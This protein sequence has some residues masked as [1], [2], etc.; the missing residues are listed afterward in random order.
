MRAKLDGFILS[1]EQVLDRIGEARGDESEFDLYRRAVAYHRRADTARALEGVDGLL[2]RRPNDPYYH[3]LRGQFLYE[4]ARPEEAVEAYRR[5]LALAP[6]EPLIAG[7]LGRALLAV[8]GAANDAEAL[9]ALQR[10][11]RGD[12]GSPGIMRDL[13]IAHGRAGEDGLAALASAERLAMLGQWSDA[14]ALA[15]RALG[16]LPTGSPGWRRADDLLALA[17]QR[18]RQ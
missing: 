9:S 1:P 8:G 18:R 15:Q 4:G 13:A 3:A 16:L 12:P 17:E 14:G 2:A 10:A 7:N 5:A 6:D 11:V